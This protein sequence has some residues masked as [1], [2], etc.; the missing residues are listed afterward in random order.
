MQP[1]WI[2]MYDD[3]NSWGWSQTDR[4]FFKDQ[5]TEFRKWWTEE[6]NNL[7]SGEHC[8]QMFDNG[9]WN[10]EH[11]NE[12]FPSVCF[13]G[14]GTFTL[15][16]NSMTW[17]AA[18]SYCRACNNDLASVRNE[19]DNQKIKELISPGQTVWIGL[20]RDSWKWLDGSDNS[21]TYWKQGEPNNRIKKETCVAADL[22]QS[23]KW[24]DRPCSETAAF[25]CYSRVVPIKKVM[26]VKLVT[27]D[28]P[29]DLNDSAVMVDLLKQLK[30]RLKAKGVTE[31]VKLSW[32]KQSD[33]KV[34][35]KEEKKMKRKPTAKKDEF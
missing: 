2:G 34:F 32:R 11:C 17:A 20:F 13:N 31:G 23:S 12:T 26:K 24:E 3:V 16:N 15:I 8:V 21:F 30:Q 25:I 6:Q 35:H 29:L 33:G 7:H 9:Y 18:Q 22:G 27:K 5:E 4:S 14:G 19:A 10:D 28:S 1:A